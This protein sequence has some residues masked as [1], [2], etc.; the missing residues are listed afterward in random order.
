MRD[1]VPRRKTRSD[2]N[3]ELLG[4]AGLHPVPI[5]RAGG[6]RDLPNHLPFLF[7]PHALLLSRTMP[8]AYVSRAR[9]RTRTGCLECRCPAYPFEASHTDMS[10]N[11]V[12]R[13]TR[14]AMSGDRNVRDA[15]EKALHAPGQQPSVNLWMAV[16]ERLRDGIQAE[17]SRLI[18]T[19]ISP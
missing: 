17:D 4:I 12:V 14:S 9:V 11:Q 19:S 2:R 16:D 3:S 13:A 7:P 5:P 18:Q 15:A 8:G 10:M 6:V 1:M